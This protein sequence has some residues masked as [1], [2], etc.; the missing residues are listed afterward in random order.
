MTEADPDVVQ[1]RKARSTGTVVQVVDNR[2]GCIDVDPDLPWFTICVDHGGC[3][4]H[5]SRKDAM[6]WASAPEGWCP[7][8]QEEALTP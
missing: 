8:C 2:N 5:R 7:T 4:G 6:L 1:E 3:V